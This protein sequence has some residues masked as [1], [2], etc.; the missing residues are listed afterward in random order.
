MSSF[1]IRSWY[2]TN[3]PKYFSEFG[4]G[5]RFWQPKYHSFEIYQRQ[6]QEEKLTYMHQNPVKTGLVKLATD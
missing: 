3:A 2:R 4:E 5:N 6:K 1:E